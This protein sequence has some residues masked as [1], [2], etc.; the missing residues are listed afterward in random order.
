MGNAEQ[1]SMNVVRVSKEEAR[2]ITWLRDACLSNRDSLSLGR[3]LLVGIAV[4]EDY[5]VSADG[6]RMHTTPTPEALQPFVGKVVQI[7]SVP[8]KG[9]VVEVTVLGDADDYPKL[10]QIIPQRDPIIEFHVSPRLLAS[11]VKAMET[12]GLAPLSA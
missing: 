11:V 2:L 7:D 9:G 1:N 12:M 4:K 10:D 5:C 6:F 8:A 3:P